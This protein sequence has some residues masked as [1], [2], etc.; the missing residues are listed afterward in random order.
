MYKYFIKKLW[1]QEMYCV[2]TFG[3]PQSRRYLFFQNLQKSY[4]FP[5]CYQKWLLKIQL[6][7][8]F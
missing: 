1:N 8:Q 5:L 6:Y 4:Q 3:V 2:N 7:C